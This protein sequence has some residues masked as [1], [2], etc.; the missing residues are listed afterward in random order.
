MAEE[1]VRRATE[2]WREAYRRQMEGDLEGAIDLYRRS[3]EVFP[4]AEAHTYLGWTLSFQGRLEDATRECVR[5]IEIDPDFIAA[6][7]ELLQN[8]RPGDR[9]AFGLKDV[10]GA[11]LV[12]AVERL[13]ARR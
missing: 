9:I 5:A 6:S 2:L 13:G 7:T 11:L 1:R 8:L 4:T 10:P 12:V 3:I